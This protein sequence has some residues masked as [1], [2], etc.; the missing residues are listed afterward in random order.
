MANRV[1]SPVGSC[2]Q[3]APGH[4]QR[5]RLLE[6]DADAPFVREADIAVAL[7]GT[8]SAESYL[9][10]EQIIAAAVASGAD[11]VHPG[12]GFLS[13]NAQ[14]ARDVTEAGLIWVGPKP[15]SIVA[16]SGKVA[17]KRLVA[18]AGVPLLPGAEPG[19]GEVE[20][21]ALLGIGE[22]VG[23]PLLVKA[24][25]GGGGRVCGWSNEPRT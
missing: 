16:M 2:A 12:Y 4:H 5:C 15:G 3:R 25:A 22:S 17:A 6:P 8:T 21:Q 7:R 14:F 10:S 11:A 23:Y 13:E 9:D 18:A 20:G 24:S 19:D 1:R